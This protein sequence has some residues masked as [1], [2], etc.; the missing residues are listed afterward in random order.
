M[1]RH[2]WL[3]AVAE[4]IEVAL[5]NVQI[6]WPD[7]NTVGMTRG[8][9]VIVLYATPEVIYASPSVSSGSSIQDR[10]VNPV[11]H[12]EVSSFEPSNLTIQPAVDLLKDHLAA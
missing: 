11:Q 10:L 1:N 8:S 6:S 5:D 7:E 9:R 4:R 2:K 12:L 3:T